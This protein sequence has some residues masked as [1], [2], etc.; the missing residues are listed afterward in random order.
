[1]PDSGMKVYQ[2]GKEKRAAKPWSIVV[3]CAVR[4]VEHGGARV[5]ACGSA[6]GFRGSGSFS[7]F[8]WSCSTLDRAGVEPSALLS[9]GCALKSNVSRLLVCGKRV[10]RMLRR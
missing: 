8:F 5:T 3:A 7:G 6:S 2:S 1:V 9:D 4:R 10:A